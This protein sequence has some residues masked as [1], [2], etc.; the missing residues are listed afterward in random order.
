MTGYKVSCWRYI[1]TIADPIM[2]IDGNY[3]IGMRGRGQAGGY[4]SK[5]RVIIILL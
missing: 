2:E 1:I 3:S 5:M 4:L